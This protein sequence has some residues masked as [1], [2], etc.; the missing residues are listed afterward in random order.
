MKAVAKAA[1]MLAAMTPTDVLLAVALADE[2]RKGNGSA[3]P[4]KVTT[5]AKATAAPVRKRRKRRTP[6]QMAADKVKED[7]AKKARAEEREAAKKAKLTAGQPAKN[8]APAPD[9]TQAPAPTP[10]GSKGSKDGAFKDP[11]AGEKVKT[12]TGEERSV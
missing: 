8:L 1:V 10:T 11:Y 5:P 3:A 12:T 9:A 2:L 7:A 6:E 4:A